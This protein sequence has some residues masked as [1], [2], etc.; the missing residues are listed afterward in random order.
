MWGSW[1]NQGSETFAHSRWLLLQEGINVIQKNE[2]C[3]LIKSSKQQYYHF[4]EINTIYGAKEL[5]TT[6][7]DFDS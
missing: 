4:G 2:C 1:E 3:H 5:T 6:L 7:G